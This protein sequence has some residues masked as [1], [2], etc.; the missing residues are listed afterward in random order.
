A[1]AEVAGEDARD[2]AATIARRML[3]LLAAAACGFVALLM[4]CTV[5]LAL[6]W[7]GP[8]RVWV[9]A[10]LAL[11]FAA[12]AAALAIP[13]LKRG[14]TRHALFFPRIRSELSRDRELLERAFDGRERAVNGGEHATD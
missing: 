13:A 9:A 14:A 1:Y 6:A 8:W 4:L 11:G 10:G 3:A 7:D 5:V 12:A 2:A